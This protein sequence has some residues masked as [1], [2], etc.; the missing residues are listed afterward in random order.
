MS[1][2]DSMSDEEEDDFKN[3]DYD[4]NIKDDILKPASTRSKIVVNL[5][6]K[7]D[8]NGR[9]LP[10]R[11]E[12]DPYDEVRMKL[13]HPDRRLY[14]Q[15]EQTIKR[16]CEDVKLQPK[17]RKMPF[18]FTLPAWGAEIVFMLIFVYIFF[19]IIQLALFNL[20]I[21]GIIVVFLKKLFYLAEALRWKLMFSYKT[22]DFN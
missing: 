1:D 9:D 19:L 7:K 11:Y 21:I 15:Y 13:I 6:D 14:I 8:E 12:L 10:I 5:V 20:V 18:Y 22:K 2:E 3:E 4:P 17:R 16:L